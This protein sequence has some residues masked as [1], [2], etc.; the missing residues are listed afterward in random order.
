MRRPTQSLAQGLGTSLLHEV[1]E[2]VGMRSLEERGMRC[3]VRGAAIPSRHIPSQSFLIEIRTYA[4]VQR[5]RK[6]SEVFEGAYRSSSSV[7]ILDGLEVLT[8]LA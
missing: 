4:Y 3:C 5:V 7:V 6:I 1:L 8:L 2:D